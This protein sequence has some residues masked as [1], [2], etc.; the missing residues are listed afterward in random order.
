MSK[1]SNHETLNHCWV[2]V[3]PSSSTLIQ[4]LP[5]IGSTSRVCFV[6]ALFE[7]FNYVHKGHACKIVCMYTDM[8][9]QKAVTAHFSS[10]QLQ[11]F[12]FAA[13]PAIRAS[14]VIVHNGY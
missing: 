1:P 8:Q 12:V 11:P 4:H 6:S 3:G 10:E 5:N 14:G 13:R 2:D 9:T 7:Q